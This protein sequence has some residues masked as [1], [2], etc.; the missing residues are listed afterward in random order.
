[1]RYH[2]SMNHLSEILLLSPAERIVLVQDIW[3]S[4]A[5]SPE[6]VPVPTEHLEELRRRSD[7]EARGEM[8]LSPWAAVK[9][10]ILSRL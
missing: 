2:F 6:E 10:R 3:D 1:V 7:A 9:K 8:T 5:A 4:L